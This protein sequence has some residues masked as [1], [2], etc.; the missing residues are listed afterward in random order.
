MEKDFDQLHY[1]NFP[2]KEIQLEFKFSLENTH[3]ARTQ[4]ISITFSHIT[5]SI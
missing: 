2:G 3:H 5:A 4:I 1:S